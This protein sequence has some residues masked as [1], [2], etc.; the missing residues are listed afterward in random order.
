MF[1][2]FRTTHFD[3]EIQNSSSTLEHQVDEFVE[4]GSGWVIKQFVDI[5][6]QVFEYDPM[7][8]YASSDTDDDADDHELSF[9]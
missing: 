7:L 5:V 2:G 3:S 6:A 1:R 4:R 9:V 8:A